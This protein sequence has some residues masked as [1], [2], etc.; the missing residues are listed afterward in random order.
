M[1]YTI[2][3]DTLLCKIE[4]VG[5]EIRSLTVKRTGRE[6]IWPINP[7]VWGSSSPVL[8]P[9]I[10]SI[11]DGMIS[12][13]GKDYAMTKHGI[14]R[15]NRDLEFQKLSSGQCAFS[16]KSSEKTNSRYPFDFRFSVDYKLLE[17]RL[18]MTYIIENKDNDSL[19]FSCGGHTAYR[20]HLDDLTQLADYVIEFPGHITHLVAETLGSSGLL[21]YRQRNYNLENHC[22]KLSDSIF[23]EDALIF[24]GIDFDWVRLRRQKAKKG[25]VV[26]FKDYPNL[27]LWSKP[28]ADYVCIEPWLGLPDR[29]DESVQLTE[30]KTYQQLKPQKRFSISIETEIE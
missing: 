7:A 23:S 14:I 4:S 25:I 20:L 30:K 22:L 18:I 21:S 17:N 9:A 2:E 13:K 5:A 8:F 12:H 24:E 27:A 26:R 1:L 15:N 10:G 29:E 16:L 28:K 19:Y 3:N 6:H 11:K